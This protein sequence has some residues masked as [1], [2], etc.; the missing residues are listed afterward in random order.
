MLHVLFLAGT[1]FQV[2]I[3]MPRINNSYSLTP[4]PQEASVGKGAGD[5][6]LL[7]HEKI[8]L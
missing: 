5:Q 7:I 8:I 1:K 6:K 3:R 4:N 2:L